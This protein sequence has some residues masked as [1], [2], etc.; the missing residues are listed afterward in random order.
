MKYTKPYLFIK[1][2]L[3]M[4]LEFFLISWIVVT[5]T[6]VL[7]HSLPGR[8]GLTAGPGLTQEQINTINAKYGLDQTLTKQYF[9]Y[10]GG[11]FSGNLGISTGIH[12]GLEIEKF[13][14]GKF[15]TSFQVGVISLFI[16]WIIGIPVGIYVGSR[17][18]GI[19]DSI[20]SI[21]V[22]I[23]LAIPGFAMGLLFLIFA[24]DTGL[25]YL[26]DKGDGWTLIIP[27]LALAIG[28][29]ITYIKFLRTEINTQINSQ[30]AKFAMAKGVKA[31]R[32]VW[33][34]ALRPA[35]FPIA[36]FFPMAVI[37]S[38][39]GSI[40]IETIFGI[41]GA[42]QLMINGINSK[43]YNVIQFLVVLYTLLTIISY[44]LRDG[45]YRLLDPRARGK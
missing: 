24:S 25:P 22:A 1:R 45:M 17:P 44:Q 9:S 36:T 12:P 43:D 21:F 4:L 16:G 23:I 40:F 34:H 11:L 18:N 31:R 13:I 10:I 7:I 3:L 37:G 29:V 30:H 20:S 26:Y 15:L 33:R 32:F 14:W 5:V 2:S 28:T 35:F 38:F 41:P 8:T 6:F 19:A 42:G 39:L 27:A